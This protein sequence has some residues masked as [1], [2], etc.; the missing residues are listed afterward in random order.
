[1]IKTNNTILTELHNI[2]DNLNALFNEFSKENAYEGYVDE[3]LGH[4]EQS[5]V[6]LREVTNKAIENSKETK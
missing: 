3:K 1:M 6:Y 5:C 4:I 2:Q